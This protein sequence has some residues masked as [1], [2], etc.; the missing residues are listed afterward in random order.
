M[1]I[2]A[3]TR[4]TPVG[5][6]VTFTVVIA[7]YNR[8]ND[9]RDTMNSLAAVRTSYGWETIVVDNNSSDNTAFVVAEAG[10]RFPVALRYL[11]E[12]EQGKA[13]AL[14]TAIRAATGDILVFTDDDVRVPSD[15]LDRTHAGFER[16]GC[17]YV[18]GK[19]LPLWCTPRPAWI[20]DRS[21]Q[22]WG[23]LALLD[24]GPEPLEFGGRVPLGVNLAVRRA[25]FSQH[26]LWWDNAFDRKGGSLRG[27]GQREWCIR[28]RDAGLRGFY[29]PDMII[30]HTV[31]RD[32]LQ[33]RYFRRWM[34]WKGISRAVMY[35]QT[36]RDMEVPERTELNFSKVPHIAG[37]PRYMY[38]HLVRSLL[39]MMRWSLLRR[40]SIAAFE[41][42]MW[43]W[44]F[45]GVVRQRW[46]DRS[47][48]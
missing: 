14:N 6:D 17:D 2:S 12:P 47:R 8:A 32:R 45:A 24:Y 13:A 35:A 18:G 31:Q 19:A 26:N 30:Y 23:V 16:F 1:E 39:E 11:F 43:L 36:G 28:A 4:T 40:D 41:H 42:E 10:R 33:K 37:V 21:S 34:Y 22:H 27:Q 25:A 3:S 9:L 29:V 44:F 48:K 46:I 20:P 38:R 7:T 5:H 15:W